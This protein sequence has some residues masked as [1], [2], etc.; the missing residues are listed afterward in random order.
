MTVAIAK[1]QHPSTDRL[2]GLVNRVNLAL[3]GV[4]YEQFTP[5]ANN[6]LVRPADPKS[7]TA[8]GI[9]VPERARGDMNIGVVV[10]VSDNETEY[11]VGTVVLFNVGIAKIEIGGESFV[12]LQRNNDIGD[13]ILGTISLDNG[14]LT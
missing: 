4:S 9:I 7:V 5:A 6:V 11:P 1:E 12:I 3:D 8:G 13:E 14:E 10:R 2:A